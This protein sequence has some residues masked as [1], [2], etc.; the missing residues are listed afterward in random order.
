M[1]SNTDNF[2][3]YK[4]MLL[5]FVP[6]LV[7]AVGLA[8]GISGSIHAANREASAA[9]IHGLERSIDRLDSKLD[10]LIE[11]AIDAD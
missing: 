11:R 9:A 3:T 6:G 5:H 8:T 2:V 10:M 1:A 4:V 7:A